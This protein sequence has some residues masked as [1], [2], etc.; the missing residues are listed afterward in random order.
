MNVSDSSSWKWESKAFQRMGYQV[1]KVGSQ[2]IR[3]KNGLL[4]IRFICFT[5]WHFICISSH[6]KKFTLFFL[7]KFAYLYYISKRVKRFQTKN[8]QIWHLKLLVRAS[9]IQKMKGVFFIVTGKC[10][11][12]FKVEENWSLPKMKP[13][14]VFKWRLFEMTISLW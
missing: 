6:R 13:N 2:M 8:N 12:L 5:F 11:H 9:L 14:L 1:E 7:P 3:T 10:I 4:N